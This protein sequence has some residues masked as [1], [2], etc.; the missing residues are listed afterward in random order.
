MKF[1]H[2]KSYFLYDFTH[3][4][5]YL[6]V[7]SRLVQL[8]FALSKLVRLKLDPYTINK[9]KLLVSCK[10]HHCDI[11][12]EERQLWNIQQKMFSV[13]FPFSLCQNGICVAMTMKKLQFSVSEV[14]HK[15]FNTL[16]DFLILFIVTI[17]TQCGQF[18]QHFM[19]AFVAIF[20]RQKKFKS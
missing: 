16:A 5:T 8:T 15:C 14:V 10:W 4:V 13:Q 19:S 11:L 17:L 7:L 2:P 3:K 6:L 1:N 12:E 18:H 20:L 9:L